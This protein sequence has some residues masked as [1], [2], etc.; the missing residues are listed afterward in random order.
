MESLIHQTAVIDEN[1]SIGEGSR[2]WHFSHIMTGASVGSGCVIG[3]NCFVADGASI[4]NGAKIQNNVSVYSG[5]TIGERAFI[6]PGVVFTNIKTP[7]AFIDRHSEYIKTEIM[8]GASI[9]GGSVILCG[10]TV[11]R[12]AIVGAGSVV[13]RDLPDYAVALGNPAKIYARACRC[14]AVIRRPLK[15]CPMCGKEL[16]AVEFTFEEE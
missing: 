7:R 14:G 2:V 12:Y 16:P 10:V 1:A 13:T 5:V 4:G 9:G 6:G 8:P 11:G 3:Q 15:Y